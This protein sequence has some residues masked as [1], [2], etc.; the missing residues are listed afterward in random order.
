MHQI[1]APEPQQ[2]K[3][4]SQLAILLLSLS[5]VPI[6][7]L[8]KL[9]EIAAVIV[10]ALLFI[11][12]FGVL[13]MWAITQNHADALRHLAYFGLPLVGIGLIQFFVGY[14]QAYYH[15]WAVKND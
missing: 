12:L 9:W 8:V 2:R 15:H 13:L 4:R 11:C 3:P 1:E 6:F 7:L 14:C 5:L 10:A